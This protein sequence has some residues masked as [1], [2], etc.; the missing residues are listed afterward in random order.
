MPYWNDQTPT[1][2][3]ERFKNTE[4]TPRHTGSLLRR[5]IMCHGATLRISLEEKTCEPD[6]GADA[7][8]TYRLMCVDTLVSRLAGVS[9][10]AM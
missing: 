4:T 6:A 9:N 10:V 7:A 2:V 3:S 5:R 8:C 1:S